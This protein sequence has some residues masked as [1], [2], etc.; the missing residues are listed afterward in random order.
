MHRAAIAYSLLKR[1]EDTVSL[2]ERVVPIREQKLG[3]DDP[4]TMA[5]E[6]DLKFYRGKMIST[7]VRR[8]VSLELEDR[9]RI[10]NRPR[11]FSFQPGTLRSSTVR[12]K[13]EQIEAE[14]AK[15]DEQEKAMEKALDDD[16]NALESAEKAILAGETEDVARNEGDN[17]S[18][19]GGRIM[20]DNEQDEEEEE[21]LVL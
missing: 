2:L 15:L 12:K 20:D 13:M 16:I 3:F 4:L 5:A 11:R 21:P 8:R 18:E 6:K 10:D 1:Y 14:L 17:G 9:P 19:N 7:P